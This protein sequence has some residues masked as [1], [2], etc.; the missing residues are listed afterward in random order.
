[1]LVDVTSPYGSGYS[2]TWVIS[3]IGVNHAVNTISVNGAGLTGGK[4]TPNISVVVR[5]PYSS[6]VTVEPIDARFLSTHS[7]T[8]NILVQTNG[9]SAVCLTNCSYA[10]LDLFTITSLALS[11][12]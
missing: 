6:D 5:R 4:T 10:F 9:I 11:S 8:P 2:I 3:Y 12:A 7:N 1:V